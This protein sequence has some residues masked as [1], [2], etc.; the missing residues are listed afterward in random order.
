MSHL[1]RVKVLA[2]QLEVGMFISDID[3]DWSDT[4]F[5]MQ[6]FTV[7]DQSDIESVQS[8]CD[9]VYVD[10]PNE[11]L[12]KR[13]RAQAT[14][15]T[16]LKEKFAKDLGFS[17]QAEIKP[18]AK[19]Y[20]KS[21][22]LMKGVLERVMLGEDFE[23]AAVK[24]QVKEC[25]Q[26][27]IR[28]ENAMLMMT[29]IKHKDEYTAEHCLNVGIMAIAFAKFLGY[30][31]QALED[32][33][34]AGMLHDIGKVKVPDSILNKPGRLTDEEMVAMR[35]HARL[36]YEILLKKKDMSPVA[37]DVAYNHHEQL[38]GGGY[39]RGLTEHQI[40]ENTRIVSIVDAFDAI[41]SDRCYDNSRPIM[42]AYKILMQYRESHF[43]PKLVT[44]FIEWR[45]IYP[46]GSIVEMEN[47][48]VGIVIATNARYKLRPKVLLVLDELKKK[49]Q[50]ERIIDMS[51]LDLD[52]SAQT[53]RIIK[54][55]QN[56]AFGI[57]LQEYVDKGLKIAAV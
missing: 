52:A 27:I 3:R 23:L 56:R 43:D 9:Y 37:I 18:A 32:V 4:N 19:A 22:Q 55:V 1:K 8:Q 54:A 20:K 44:R 10:F 35:D 28:N 45:G 5:L 57:D 46:P 12:Y 36:G 21:R 53:Y 38:G 41:T 6:G 14:V 39:P 7:E 31:Q 25:V 42:E 16:T 48:E 17:V 2:N 51:K 30:E 40:S 11:D 15:S 13:F 24:E 47:G 33:G 26:S 50:K 49:R 34:L 29:L